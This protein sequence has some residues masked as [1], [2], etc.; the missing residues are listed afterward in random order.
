[1]PTGNFLSRA[2]LWSQAQVIL[3]QWG[4]LLCDPYYPQPIL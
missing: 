1:M 3:P 2:A 4:D